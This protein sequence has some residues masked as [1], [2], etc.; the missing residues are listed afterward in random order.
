MR[1]G[2]LGEQVLPLRIFFRT[3]KIFCYLRQSCHS[4]LIRISLHIISATN[5]LVKYSY[6]WLYNT[7]IPIDIYFTLQ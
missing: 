5:K 7:L 4:I 1:R 6:I 2:K 3:H